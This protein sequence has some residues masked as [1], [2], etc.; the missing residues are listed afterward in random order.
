MEVLFE[1]ET[2]TRALKS[3]AVRERLQRDGGGSQWASVHVLD[4]SKQG[5]RDDAAEIEGWACGWRYAYSCALRE[6]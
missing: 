4:V 1:A 6:R 5:V 3:H 2:G